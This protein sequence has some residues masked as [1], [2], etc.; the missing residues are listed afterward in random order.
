MIQSDMQRTLR[1]KKLRTV[2]YYAYDGKC[3]ICGAELEGGWEADHIVPWVKTKRTN[4]HEMQPL[5]REC[6]RKKGVRMLRKHQAEMSEVTKLIAADSGVTDV[7][8]YVTPGGGK[9]MLPAIIAKNI[10]E[11]KGYKLLWIVPRN[12]LRTQGEKSM[13]DTYAIS[14][15]GHSG[16]LRAAGNDANPSRGTLGYI[17]NYQTIVANPELHKQ[18]LERA[19]LRGTPY[20][21]FFDEW[22]HVPVSDDESD[23]SE[24]K[25]YYKAVAPLLP[26][27][28]VR[29]FASGTLDRHDKKRIAHLPYT[30]SGGGMF[31]NL[32]PP[33]PWTSIRY[34]RKDALEEGAICPLVMH[35]ADGAATWLN[36]RGDVVEVSESASVTKKDNR[37]YVR[38]MLESEYAFSLIDDCITRW[39]DYRRNVFS[40][41]K[42]L[43]IAP[44][45][46][47]AGQYYEYLQDIGISCDKAV[48]MDEEGNSTSKE[49]ELAI[50][51]F[52]QTGPRAT[53]VL[54]TVAMA[55]EGLDVPEI[56]HIVLLTKYR[57]PSW[58]EQAIS[59]GNRVCRN[60]PEKTHGYIFA[61][62]DPEMREV[63]DKIEKEQQGVVVNIPRRPPVQKGDD[64]PRSERKEIVPL[65]SRLTRFRSRTL[66]GG[67]ETNWE[68]D[69][70]LRRLMAE[71]GIYA[72]PAQFIKVLTGMGMT[73][74]NEPNGSSNPPAVPLPPLSE[75]ESTLKKNILT[76]VNS[77]GRGDPEIIMDI[78][79]A[80]KERYGSISDLSYEELQDQWRWL[81]DT[82][83]GGVNYGNN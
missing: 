50:K 40:Q 42:V 45:I 12:N 60:H 37:Q 80:A 68:E 2:L 64:G 79:T 24:E 78:R 70:M 26:L 43:V 82:F 77:V 34:S 76:Y 54:I 32:N 30:S 16:E 41:A 49:A 56:T 13:I 33:A 71:N 72:S 4:V 11:P 66:D 47:A 53:N 74:P 67:H 59:R 38:A 29:I 6:N 3:A 44:G 75:R 62:D 48:S 9:S 61:P 57:S 18:E 73:Q 21:I 28:A 20:V 1:S 15:V 39:D 63:L 65:S 51:R 8:A 19:F 36:E 52:S 83:P 10:C 55:Y 58:I 25:A 23:Y 7:L 46:K 69:E 27:A 81:N 22:H 14:L 35:Y 31:V 17:T 5:C